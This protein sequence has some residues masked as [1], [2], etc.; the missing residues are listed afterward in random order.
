MFCAGEKFNQRG[1][2]THRDLA[3]GFRAS[4]SLWFVIDLG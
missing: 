1:T 2:E 3:E 4:G